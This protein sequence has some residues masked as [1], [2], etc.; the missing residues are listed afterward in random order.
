[1]H[2]TNSGPCTN[3]PRC[4]C[5]IPN[6]G[7]DSNQINKEANRENVISNKSLTVNRDGSDKTRTTAVA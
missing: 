5:I 1:M 2:T 7:M 3:K 6:N 4:K